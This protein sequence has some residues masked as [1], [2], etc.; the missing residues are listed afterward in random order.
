MKTTLVNSVKWG[1]GAAVLSLSTLGHADLITN[2]TFSADSD[3]DPVGVSIDTGKA[4]GPSGNEASGTIKQSIGSLNSGAFY[5]L[6]FFV[7]SPG[8]GTFDVSF[9]SLSFDDLDFVTNVVN[10]ETK[11]SGVVTGVLSGDLIF[12][13]TLDNQSSTSVPRGEWTLDNVSLVCD[14][15]AGG[16]DPTTSVPEPGSLLLVGAALAGLG[17]ARR[18]KVL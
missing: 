10:G 18:R 14:T 7:G 2:G 13:F 3:W 12:T 1:L 15:A 11:Y 6:D 8:A 17:L 4:R 9:G 5:L 16:C